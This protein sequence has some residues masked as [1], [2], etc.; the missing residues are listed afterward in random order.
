MTGLDPALF[1]SVSIDGGGLS[2]SGMPWLKS[3]N[4]I[5]SHMSSS[6]SGEKLVVV[7]WETAEVESSEGLEIDEMYSSNAWCIVASSA[8]LACGNAWTAFFGGV[9]VH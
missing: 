5:A 2:S 8:G 6:S 4:V 1:A 7:S 3:S 9:A